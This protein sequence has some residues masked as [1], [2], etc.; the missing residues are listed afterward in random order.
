MNMDPRKIIIRPILTEK[1]TRLRDAEN[2][3][4]FEV[5]RTANK[6]EIKKAV[7]ELFGVEVAKVRTIN[8]KGKV[9][10]VGRFQGKRRDWKKAIVTLKEGHA[11]QLFE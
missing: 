10:R 8:V 4:T 7:E 6:I 11:I 1:S 5:E 2:K 3:Y 9:R